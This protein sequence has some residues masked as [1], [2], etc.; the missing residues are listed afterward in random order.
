[1]ALQRRVP[2]TIK[3]SV[4][5]APVGGVDVRVNL[6]DTDINSCIYAFNIMPSEVGMQVRSGY[7]EWAIGVPGAGGVRTIIPFIGSAPGAADDRLFVTSNAGIFDVTIEA[8]APVTEIIFANQADTAGWGTFCHYVDDD[9]DEFILYADSQNGLFEY[10]LDT[11]AWA[12]SANITGPVVE[13]IIFAVVH[14]QRLWLVESGATSAWYLPIGSKQGTA[15]EFF[16]GGK[17]RHG[18]KLT[19][20]YNWSVDGGDGVDD[21]LI[22]ISGGGDVIPYRGADPSAAETWDV[23][24]TYFIGALPRGV[25]GASEFG[26]DLRLLS[27]YGM[28]SMSDLLTG[29]NVEDVDKSSEGFKIARLV[30]EDMVETRNDFGWEIK[31]IPGE[32]SLVVTRPPRVGRDSIQYVYNFIKRGWGLWRGLEMQTI[33][34]W[35][36]NIYFGD[37]DGRVLLMA[38]DRDN[39]KITP[40]FPSPVPNGVAIEYSL[41]TQYTHLGTPGIWKRGAAIRPDFQFGTA[42]EYITRFLYDY[43]LSELAGGG[44]LPDPPDPDDGSLWDFAEWDQGIWEDDDDIS[45]GGGQPPT[46]LVRGSWDMGRVLAVALKG[47]ALGRLTLLSFDIMWTEGGPL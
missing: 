14:K 25:R 41:L 43:D 15:E 36:D 45:G 18:G 46:A 6:A 10:S 4:L 26:G 1:M 24:G 7:R 9:G 16:F 2:P 40:D 21:Y 29:V 32:S 37:A 17:F 35:R 42:I 27:V 11:D 38:G 44:F 47:S 30:R 19:G 13:D 3:A 34:N 33:D 20:L 39:V 31:T 5:P 28:I 23:V 22:A 8:A 12:Q